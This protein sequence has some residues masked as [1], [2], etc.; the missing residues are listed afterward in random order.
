MLGDV[1]DGWANKEGL[2]EREIDV[3]HILVCASGRGFVE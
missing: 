2:R 3:L 1:E